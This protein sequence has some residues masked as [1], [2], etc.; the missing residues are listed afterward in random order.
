M[1]C[2]ECSVEIPPAWK[3]AYQQNYCPS[4]GGSIFNEEIVELMNGLKSAL[5]QMPNDPQGIAGWLLSNY[6]MEKV[7]DG[8][9][10]GFFGPKEKEEAKEGEVKV[11]QSKL[12][13]FLKNAGVDTSKKS[14][15]RMAVLAQQIS[16]IDEEEEEVEYNDPY[17][18][19]NENEFIEEE[20]DPEFTKAVL[21]GMS[22][23]SAKPKLSIRELQQI[24]ELSSVNLSQNDLPKDLHEDRMLRLMKQKEL[25]QSGQVGK[26]RRS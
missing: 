17:E 6:K 7:G 12:E 1:K 16:N 23:T 11:A 20:T 19:E 4:C 9:P 3:H 18:N 25:N 21:N 24:Q 8:E 14:K 22:P 5:E 10:T 13:R 26:I 2:S 15:N